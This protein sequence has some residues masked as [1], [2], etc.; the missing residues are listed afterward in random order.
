MQTNNDGFTTQ[1]S[2]LE[3]DYESDDFDESVSGE[4]EFSYPNTISDNGIEF[5][6]ECSVTLSN[7]AIVRYRLL[8]LLM[9]EFYTKFHEKQ[10]VQ[11]G[12]RFL[13]QSPGNTSSGGASSSRQPVAEPSSQNSQYN[14]ATPV[15]NIRHGRKH[16]AGGDDDD[17]DDDESNKRPRLFPDR[18]RGMAPPPNFLCPFHKRYPTI[19]GMN[20]G[21]SST[22]WPDIARLK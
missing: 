22:G 13:T 16:K 17:G 15:Q 1:H 6:S 8:S 5:R 12:A 3:E 4:Q 11:H 9:K 20:T 14:P 2:E 19:F 18:S 21:C 7:I 10:T